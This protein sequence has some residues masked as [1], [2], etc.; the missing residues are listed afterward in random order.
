MA[1]IDVGTKDA[2]GQT[3]DVHLLTPTDEILEWDR[4]GALLRFDPEPGNFIG[5]EES[6]VRQL[7]NEGRLAYSTA[8]NAN[9]ELEREAEGQRATST[10]GLDIQYSPT[11]GQGSASRRVRIDGQ[12]EGMHYYWAGAWEY[13]DRVTEGYQ[14]VGRDEVRTASQTPSNS[15]Q[16]MRNG[17]PEHILLKIPE[18]RYQAHLK[19][20]GNMSSLAVKGNEEGVM[21]KLKQAGGKPFKGEAPVGS[22]V[23]WNAPTEGS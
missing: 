5:L 22:D 2:E 19:A 21:E 14:V 10:P 15:H 17:Q 1:D 13:K 6:F 20:V 7:S 12:E 23:R 16:L 9:I 8:R 4:E 18:E 11:L 3:I